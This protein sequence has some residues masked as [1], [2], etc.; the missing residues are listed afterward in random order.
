MDEALR[1]LNTAALVSIES[2]APLFA[3]FQHVLIR[4]VCYNTLLPGVRQAMHRRFVLYLEEA[5]GQGA[6]GASALLIAPSCADRAA[7]TARPTAG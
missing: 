4:D 3:A 6:R 2:R 5:L 1:R 7:G